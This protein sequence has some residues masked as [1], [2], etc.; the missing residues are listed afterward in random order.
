MGRAMRSLLVS[1]IACA[2]LLLCFDRALNAIH[3]N[4][5]TIR[6]GNVR[7]GFLLPNFHDFEQREDGS[8]YRWSRPESM[9]VIGPVGSGGPTLVTLS[10]GG[11]PEPATL[12]LAISGLATYPLEASVVPRR[13]AFLVP[14]SGQPETRIAIQSPAYSAPG[15]PR[16]LGFILESVH[17]HLFSDTPRFPPPVFFALQLAALSGFALCL[18]R[19]RL[20]WL[21]ATVVLGA[22]LIAAIWV[23]LLPYAFL[24]LQRL[25][26]AAWVLVA[27]SWWVVPRLERSRWLA[28]PTE[29]RMLWGIALGAMILRLVGVLYPPFGGQDLSYHHL[30]RLGRAIMGGL[31]IIEPSSEFRGGSII[32]PPGL[33]LLLMPGLLLTHDWLGFVQGVLALLD[34]C[35]ALL[36]GLLA[37]RLGG[38]RTAALIAASLYAASPTAFAAHFFGFYTQIFGQWLMAPIG[39]VL[40]DEALA[41]RRR[42]LIAGALL[43]VATLTH[44]GVAILGCTWL[45]WAWLIT[46]PVE[47]RRGR[48]RA[49]ATVAL[50]LA[51]VGALAI[52]LL[53][54]DFLPTA[55]SRPLNGA[56][57]TGANWFPGAT[58]FLAR[59]MLLAFG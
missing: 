40:M 57:P 17:I 9:I 48:P 29:A 59:G 42:W 52:M 14:S 13:Y 27:L 44:I 30:P 53:Y 49:L 10:L 31:I 12:R 39:L 4:D 50:I 28:G 47:R 45:A 22:A 2:L 41:Y 20:P 55:L 18:W 23:W 5:Y 16:E 56:V 54:A 7:S 6:A 51:G 15:D 1:A 36:V 58:P 8:S 38:G 37:R 3:P 32:N 34:G 25:A 43:L 19:V 35:S 21:V 11:R 26:V 24:Y 46:L 33:Y